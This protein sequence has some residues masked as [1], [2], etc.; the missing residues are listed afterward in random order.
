[1]RKYIDKRITQLQHIMHGFFLAIATTIAEPATIL[2]IIVSHFTHNS[3]IIGLFSSLLK[4]GAI[5]VQIVA[6]FWAQ[7]FPRM[8]PYLYGVFAARFL[9][10]LGIGVAIVFLGER[11]PT[12]TL[13]AIGMGLFIFSFAAGFGTVYFNEILAKVFSHKV[14]GRTTAIRQFVSGLGAISS[15]AVAAYILNHYPAPYSYGYLFIVSAFVMLLGIIAFATIDEPVK[16]EIKQ[17]EQHFRHYLKNT[18]A[19]LREDK[20]LFH[21][22]MAYLLSYSYLFALP[23][24]ILDAK[25]HIELNGSMLG[26]FVSLQMSGAMLSNLVWGHLSYR[27]YNTRIILYAFMLFITAFSVVLIF[28]TVVSFALL[29][30]LVGSAM[31]GLKLAFGNL[32]LIIAP[33]H[34]RPVYIALQSNL[35]SIGLFFALPGSLILMLTNYTLLYLF[36]IMMLVLGFIMVWRTMSK[37]S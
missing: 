7:S 8:M 33:E 28:K 2:P 17:K 30:F 21:Q 19:L 14:R 6:A 34:K 16:K 18:F 15:G 4:G 13:V 3:L 37:E 31:D 36:T 1:M 9:A 26:L 11:H 22:I 24:V 12:L 32:I 23:F 25:A 20:R 35:S 10:W 5:V 29:F 27:G